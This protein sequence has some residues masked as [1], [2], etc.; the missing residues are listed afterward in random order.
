MAER[1]ESIV[2]RMD[3]EYRAGNY[4]NEPDSAQQR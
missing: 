4:G 1:L 3:E 2:Q